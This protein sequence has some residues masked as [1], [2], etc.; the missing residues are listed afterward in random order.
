MKML[1]RFCSDGK[2]Q[3][4]ATCTSAG[5][6]SRN[7]PRCSPFALLLLLASPAGA[8]TVLSAGDGDTMRVVAASG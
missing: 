1:C 6:R 3:K 4:A 2:V 8:A 5:Q 7:A